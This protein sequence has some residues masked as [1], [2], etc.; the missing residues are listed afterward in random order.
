MIGEWNFTSLRG[1]ALSYYRIT[2]ALESSRNKRTTLELRSHIDQLNVN[3]SERF[4]K[5]PDS[6]TQYLNFVKRLT[7]EIQFLSDCWCLSEFQHITQKIFNLYSGVRVS[8]VN[9]SFPTEIL[10]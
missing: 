6:E 8:L 10:I 2:T 4:L 9:R 3:H 1:V 7:C 5:K